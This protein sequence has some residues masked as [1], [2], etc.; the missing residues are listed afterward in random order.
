MKKLNFNNIFNCILGGAI[1]DALGVPVRNLSYDLI[2]SQYGKSGLTDMEADCDG[3]ARVTANTQLNIFTIDALVKAYTKYY[4]YRDKDLGAK[5]AYTNFL[6]WQYYQGRNIQ[7]YFDDELLKDNYLYS[8]QELKYERYPE[9]RM[10]DILE[11][12]MIQEDEDN[13]QNGNSK[14]ACLTK[15]VPYGIFFHNNYNLAFDTA[16]KIAKLTHGHPN[17]YLSCGVLAVIIASIANGEK[18]QKAIQNGIDILKKKDD[19]DDVLK[20]IALA[21]QYAKEVNHYP[22]KFDDF[23][24]CDDA[25]EVLATAIYV[26]L[27]GEGSISKALLF[28]VNNSVL[29]N[30]VAT[31]VGQILGLY[32]GLDDECKKWAE[33][34]EMYDVLKDISYDL[35]L[36]SNKKVPSEI[37][38]YDKDLVLNEMKYINVKNISNWWLIKYDKI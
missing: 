28:A 3:K 12:G 24:L 21:L 33:K 8:I 5:L 19:A 27:I 34:I 9:K 38:S 15:T 35:Y 18:M 32:S 37:E 30:N 26:C 4:I 23:G 7:G 25:H 16:V 11:T 22:E 17:A 10:I 6:R 20:L 14:W 13:S 31:V 2:V 1:G 36:V 29:G